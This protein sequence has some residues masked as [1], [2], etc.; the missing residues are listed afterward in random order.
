MK[1]SAHRA[2]KSEVAYGPLHL[3]QWVTGAGTWVQLSSVSP[4]HFDQMRLTWCA[5]TYF[6]RE[7]EHSDSHGALI[8]LQVLGDLMRASGL[9]DSAKHL[10][11]MPPA[12]PTPSTRLRPSL[13]D[14]GADQIR[15]MH[16]H[17]SEG[18]SQ[19][20]AA[21]M[22][23]LLESTASRLRRGL[24]P[25]EKMSQSAQKAYAETFGRAPEQQGKRVKRPSIVVDQ[26]NAR[27]VIAL[28]QLLYLKGFTLKDA[29]KASGVSVQMARKLSHQPADSAGPRTV[30]AWAQTF[31]RTMV[32]GTNPC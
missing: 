29:A 8:K 2:K 26:R 27:N 12:L 4:D 31:G 9:A 6:P 1:I 28:H 20:Y 24:L 11:A 15:S 13:A 22:S 17:M 3:V 7:S 23:G 14:L 25:C 16:R 18:H 19:A 30:A 10:P 21:R 32:D 5:A